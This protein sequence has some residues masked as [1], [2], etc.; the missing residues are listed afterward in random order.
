MASE[1][2]PVPVSLG[3]AQQP[4]ERADAARNRARVLQAAARLFARRGVAEVTMDDIAAEARVGKGTIYRRFGDKGGLATALL[5]E[6]ERELQRRLLSG[7][8]ALGPGAPPA[9]RLV[10]FVS[11]YLRLVLDN[12]DILEMAETNSSGARFRS[13]AYALWVTHCRVLLEEAGAADADLRAQMILAA[14]SAEQVRDWIGEQ[15]RDPDDLARG[16]AALAVALAG[17]GS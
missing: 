6:R 10:A 11:A 8:P 13:G 2:E 4:A 17:S 3:H 14:L 12:I 9:D 1:R 7:P 5:D 15:E 16:L